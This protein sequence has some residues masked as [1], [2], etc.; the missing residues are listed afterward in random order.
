MSPMSQLGE[1]STDRHDPSLIDMSSRKP[2]SISTTVCT[3][4]P[5]SKQR[6]APPVRL[7][8]PEDTA[9]SWSA[10]SLGNPV[11]D[12]S[13]SPSVEITAACATPDTRSTKL[14]TNQP[15][16]LTCAAGGPPIGG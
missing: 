15:N 4:V 16:L 2:R 12:V 5:A 7:I 10:R 3:T 6:A 13:S 8:S 11:D 9:A 1:A 14:E